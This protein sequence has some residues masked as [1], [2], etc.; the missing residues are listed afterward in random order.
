M[1]QI[2]QSVAV[3]R[4]ISL[5]LLIVYAASFNNNPFK[6]NY[7]SDKHTIRKSSVWAPGEMF[8]FYGNY[9][10]IANPEEQTLLFE[11]C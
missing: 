1:F 3:E 8:S 4:N 7:F 9:V 5:D 11:Y 2:A 10:A 6:S